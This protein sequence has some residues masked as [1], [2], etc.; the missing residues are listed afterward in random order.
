MIGMTCGQIGIVESSAGIFT[1][2]VIYAQYG[3]F[4]LYVIGLRANWDDSNQNNLLDSYG[5]EWVRSLQSRPSEVK[6]LS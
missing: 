5:Q 4:P 6:S 2:F 3:F 1:Y